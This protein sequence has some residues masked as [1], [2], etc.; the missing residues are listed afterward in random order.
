MKL[1][2]VLND[3]HIFDIGALILLQT[4]HIVVSCD[5]P[6]NKEFNHF[7]RHKKRDWDE[8]VQQLKVSHECQQA[9]DNW[10]RSKL[11]VEM[12]GFTLVTFRRLRSL[13]V[14][15]TAKY[16]NRK[17]QNELRDEDLDCK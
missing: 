8:S 12:D 11:N 6:R 7:C 17:S 3:A 1:A 2:K 13:T 4:K 16:G 9:L 10:T 5:E 15:E 14:P